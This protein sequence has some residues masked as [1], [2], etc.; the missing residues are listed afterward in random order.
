MIVCSVD[1]VAVHSVGIKDGCQV[2][3]VIVSYAQDTMDVIRLMNHL[4]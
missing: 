2:I 1:E 3:L 4:N